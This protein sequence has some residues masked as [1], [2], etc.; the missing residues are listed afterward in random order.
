MMASS[1]DSPSSSTKSCNFTNIQSFFDFA[2]TNGL[3]I[4][5]EV[6]RCQNLCLLTYGTGNPDLSGIGV[7]ISDDLLAI[8]D[9]TMATF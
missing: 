1:F 7:R 3:N 5:Q 4:T 9:Y 8:I 2:T 6:D